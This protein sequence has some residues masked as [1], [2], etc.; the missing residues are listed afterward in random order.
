ML[1]EQFLGTKDY[2]LFWI[3]DKNGEY[4]E[5]GIELQYIGHALPGDS[6]AWNADRTRLSAIR[7]VKHAPLVGI[8]E[9]TS[10]YTYGL[11]SR[12]AP[13]Y[14]FTPFD[15]K[16]PPFAVGS[17]EK[18][19]T[20][21]QIGIIDVDSWPATSVLPRGTLIRLFG[22]CGT[23]KAEEEG[24]LWHATP[25][26]GHKKLLLHSDP[27]VAESEWTRRCSTPTNT[28]HIDPP[29][30]KDIDD[31][32]SIQYLAE[33]DTYE[34]WIT[35]A[36]VAE[37]IPRGSEL[38]AMA[39]RL[40]QTTYRDGEAVKPMLPA[41]LSEDRLSLLPDQKRL[42]VS[43]VVEWDGETI[44]ST[45]WREVVVTVH[46]S[47]TYETVK[48]QLDGE[49]Q[50]VLSEFTEYLAQTR[51]G[52]DDPHKWIEECMILY[53]TEAGTYLEQHGCLDAIFR[54]HKGPDMDK[55]ALYEVFGADVA[56]L[57]QRSAEPCWS[58]DTDKKHFGLGRMRYCQASSPLRRYADLWNQ[59]RIKHAIHGFAFHD[60]N[61]Y[62]QTLT[63]M[64]EREK[65]LKAYERN[66][67]LLRAICGGEK[68]VDVRV[69]EAVPM[70]YTLGFLKIRLWVPEWKQVITWRTRG[71]ID[72]DEYLLY[73][74]ATGGFTRVTQGQTVKLKLFANFQSACWKERIL[75]QIV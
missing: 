44:V 72:Q 49:W 48:A 59:R 39:S 24:A 68:K 69:L 63:W 42:G 8:L 7:Q 5:N 4:I 46:D 38:D 75:F 53:N 58:S 23:L 17:A 47:Y 11:T 12:G 55:L 67:I 41:E 6:V 70:E 19:K 16:Y 35:I 37:W 57:A 31:A 18:N 65:R 74:L 30:C 45:D 34:I 62:T 64:K 40:S 14:K 28:F 54:K 56:V 20:S 52:R 50:D 43:L 21:N 22:P 13:L 27:Q 60:T 1:E 71:D 61:R 36:D 29:G 9:L 33:K 25:W 2:K 3:E 15:R 10:K 73:S 66:L 51:Q 26:P 32:I